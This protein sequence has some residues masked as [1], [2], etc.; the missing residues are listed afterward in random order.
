MAKEQ[1]VGTVTH[2]FDEPQVG[3]LELE[4][5]V[6]V[7]DVLRFEGH[8]TDFSQ[9][10]VSMEIEHESVE[11]AG[12]GDAVALKVKERVREGDVVYRVERG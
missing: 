12:P 5:D 7:G 9:E 8:T 4:R 1:R 11:R 10:I 3:A 2:Y 6:E